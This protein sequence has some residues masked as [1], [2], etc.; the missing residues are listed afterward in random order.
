[1]YEP[2]DRLVSIEVLGQRV[3]VPENNTLLRCFQYL[4]PDSLPYG[5]FCW[6]NECGHCELSYRPPGGTESREVR[7]CQFRVLEGMEVTVLSM[8]L[9]LALFPLL[10]P[11]EQSP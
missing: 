2:Y 3:E 7:G 1:V 8:Y 6:N 4:C 9:K 11:Q 10:A 5:R